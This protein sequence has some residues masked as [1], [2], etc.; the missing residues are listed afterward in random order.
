VL[1]NINLTI[2]TGEVLVLIGLC[3]RFIF[4]VTLYCYKNYNQALI[5]K[6]KIFFALLIDKTAIIDYG[7][8][9]VIV[10]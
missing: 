7:A 2:E 3:S 5:L 8:Y 1:D 10:K 6:H 9:S 4:I